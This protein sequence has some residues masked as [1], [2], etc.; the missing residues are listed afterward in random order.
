MPQK[1]TVW[2]VSAMNALSQISTSENYSVPRLQ[3]ITDPNGTSPWRD[4]HSHISWNIEGEHCWIV[5]YS[6]LYFIIIGMSCF[7]GL[8]N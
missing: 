5:T 3:N 4:I 7:S 6:S 1:T 2:N 8:C